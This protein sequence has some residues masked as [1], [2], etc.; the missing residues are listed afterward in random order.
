MAGGSDEVAG[1]GE[2]GGGHEMPV[3][4]PVADGEPAQGGGE[5]PGGKGMPGPD[6]G[7]GRLRGGRGPG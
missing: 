1:D 3:P 7:G 4:D 5:K 2:D 6:G